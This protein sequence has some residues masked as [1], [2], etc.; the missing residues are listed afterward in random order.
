MPLREYQEPGC[1]GLTGEDYWGCDSFWWAWAEWDI[2]N[3]VPAPTSGS[4][5]D[6][7]DYENTD[8]NTQQPD[9]TGDWSSWY[10][11]YGSTEAPEPDD[12]TCDFGNETTD[13]W[14]FVDIIQPI[15]CYPQDNGNAGSIYINCTSDLITFTYY[16]ENGDCDGNSDS[17]I[18]LINGCTIFD[19]SPK[20]IEVMDCQAM[21]TMRPTMD[22]TNDPTMDIDI[23]T[24]D[25]TEVTMD[26]QS[27]GWIY[28]N[29]AVFI[30]ICFVVLTMAR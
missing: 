25:K 1:D 5:D 14:D 11:W 17:E 20:V 24:S 9:N 3:W 2:Y 13:D 29:A 18:T 16:G 10:G 21:P 15:G 19:D 26:N 4:W 23:I 7:Y 6:Y 27:S 8:Y 22:P 12:L 30:M 28:S